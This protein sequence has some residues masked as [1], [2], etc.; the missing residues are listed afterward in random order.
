[1]TWLEVE[2][3]PPRHAYTKQFVPV[4]L[5]LKERNGREGKPRQYRKK[6]NTHDV[7]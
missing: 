4:R 7:V 1:M 3:N 5:A 6:D 2:Q